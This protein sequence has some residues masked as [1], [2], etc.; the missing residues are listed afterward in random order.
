MNFMYF[1]RSNMLIFFTL[2]I[3]E[4]SGQDA[5]NEQIVLDTKG[6][7]KKTNDANM[8]AGTLTQ[9]TGRI[10]KMQK[11]LQSAYTEPRGTEAR[12]YRTMI[13]NPLIENGPTPYQLN[14]LFFEYYCN[15]N[16]KTKLL[17]Q[18]TGTWF[19]VWANHFNWFAERVQYFTIKQQPVF[20]LTPRIGELNGYTLYKG[21][22]HENSNTGKKYSHAVLITRDGQMPYVAVTKKEYLQAF[23]KFNEK[24]LPEELASIEKNM[25]VK[26]PE[27]EEAN[28]L[29][30][31]EK[32][33]K[34]GGQNKQRAKDNF[35]KGY[36][37]DR[38]RKD[39]WLSDTKI[40]YEKEMKVAQDLITNSREEDL[41]Q[42]AIVKG[43]DML[44]FH[45]FSTDEKGGQQVVRLNP[46]YFNNKLPKH[47]PQFLVVYWRW[48]Y[49]K[50][51]EVFKD[52][53]E[54]NLDFSALKN[55]I[56]N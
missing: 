3:T 6:T 1:V 49:Q 35:L 53:L 37:T 20:L 23:L 56:D 51:G 43:V 12:W 11:F 8:K 39:K 17:G 14:A 38:E 48:T 31:L 22:H 47:V 36:V 41:Q 50:P 32:I 18:E 25:L 55:M 29:A 44:S 34:T 19:Y 27:Q 7:W 52:Q 26:T 45:G 4:V 21:I 42:P 46:E 15:A 10:D 33:D 24:K 5:C 30:Q 13:N 2:L 9:V 54:Q 40:R 16:T 28:K